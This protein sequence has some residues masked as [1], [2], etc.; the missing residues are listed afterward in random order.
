MAI[1]GETM[2]VKE[3]ES[4]ANKTPRKSDKC[5]TALDSFLKRSIRAASKVPKKKKRLRKKP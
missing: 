1:D 5:A 4:I 3:D 2:T